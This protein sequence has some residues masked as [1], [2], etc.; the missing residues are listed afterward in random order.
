MVIWILFGVAALLLVIGIII[1]VIAPDMNGEGKI[2]V[3]G[4][5]GLVGLVLVIVTGFMAVMPQYRLWR[6]SIE[7]RIL[8]EQAI[9][10][11]DSAVELAEAERIRA[12]GVADANAI[13]SV[14]IDEQYIRWLFVNNLADLEGATEIIY[15]PTEANLPILEADRFG[16][17]GGE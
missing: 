17:V 15:I 7:K 6:A 11:R 13:I 12:S 5:L 4:A 9:A 2:F 3:G 8:V 14:S 10:E 1:V 16:R